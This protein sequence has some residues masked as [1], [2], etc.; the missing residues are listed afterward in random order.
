[1]FILNQNKKLDF[2]MT[3][4]GLIM[5]QLQMLSIQIRVFQRVGPKP[6]IEVRVKGKYVISRLHLANCNGVGAGKETDPKDWISRE[7]RLHWTADRKIHLP[8]EAEVQFHAIVHIEL[9]I[10]AFCTFPPF[11]TSYNNPTS[12]VAPR[13]IEP[14]EPKIPQ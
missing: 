11:Y 12:T 10:L 3:E 13:L 8:E 6:V 7:I 2:L 1:M 14:R 5:G 4:P 9:Y